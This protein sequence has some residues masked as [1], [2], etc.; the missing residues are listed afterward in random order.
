[1]R[2]LIVFNQVSLDGF[3]ADAN[4]DMSWAHKSDP[5]WIAFT[6]G[7]AKGGGELCFGRK[8]YDQM[9]GFWPSAEAKKT[10][11]EVAKGMNELPKVVFSKKMRKAEWNNTRVFKDAVAGMKKLK[12]EQ[13]HDL[14]IM[15]SGTVV[16]DLAA[17]GL[18]DTW[19]LAVNPVMLGSGKKQNASELSLKLAGVR[20]FKNGNV[21]LTYTA[22]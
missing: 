18:V 15:G 6:S 20:K 5:E 22:V 3:I 13:G 21:V 19:Q 17:A 12:A 10:M 1:M 7:N 8:T 14:V 2:K 4:G 11:P 9:A 16:A